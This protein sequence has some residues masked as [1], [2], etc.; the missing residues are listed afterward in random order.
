MHTTTGDAIGTSCP[1]FLRPVATYGSAEVMCTSRQTD[2]PGQTR[3][4]TGTQSQGPPRHPGGR[5]VAD[6]TTSSAV[7]EV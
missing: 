4:E 3:R 1:W 2:R 6:P 7:A 5:P